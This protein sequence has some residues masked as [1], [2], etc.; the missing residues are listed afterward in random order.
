[1]A[2]S[3]T[4]LSKTAI[5]TLRGVL[6]T[7]SF[8]IV[9][10]AEE[11]RRRIKIA[12]AA[13]DNARRI[14]AA[15]ANRGAATTA[16]IEPFDLDAHLARLEG[17][18]FVAQSHTP[19]KPYGRERRRGIEDSSASY[20]TVATSESHATVPDARP[21]NI[22]DEPI[23]LVRIARAMAAGQSSSDIPTVKRA[24]ESRNKQRKHPTVEN[25]TD[26]VV[27]MS[28]QASATTQSV[29]VPSL[30]AQNNAVLPS[31]DLE[32]EHLIVTPRDSNEASTEYNEA[33]AV[34]IEAVQALPQKPNTNDE[35][36]HIFSTAVEAL[37]G[38]EHHGVTRRSF[39]EILKDIVVNLL[40]YS[41]DMTADEMRA[42]LKASLFLKRSLV[43][44][45]TRF[46]AWMDNYRPEDVVHVS[47]T[48]IA[49]FTQ[50][51]QAFVWKDGQLIQELIRV[52]STRCA[53]LAIKGYTNLKSAGLFARIDIPE[54]EY[55]IRREAVIAACAA[56]Q[57]RFIDDEMIVLRQ[58][59]GDDVVEA[60]FGLQA[61]LMARQ[62]TL[63]ACDTLFDS[64]RDL[65]NCKNPSSTEFQGHLHHLTDLFAKA[66]DAEQLGQWLKYVVKT[67]GMALQ[68]DWVFSVLNEYAY[69]HDI[70]GM[71]VWMEFCLGHGLKVDRNFVTEWKKTCRGHLRF[72]K[73]YLQ[74]LW[75]R[76][77][78]VTL[79]PQLEG[80]AYQVKQRQGDLSTH[81]AELTKNK[82][83]GKACL[84]FEAALSK[85]R[86]ICD[87]SLQLALEA[88]VRASQGN[89]EPA[90][91]LLQ[92]VRGHGR[93]TTIAQH[94]FLGKEIGRRPSGDIKTLLLQAV[95]CG[96]I[97]PADIYTLAVKK[98]VEKDLYA[99]HE[100]LQLGVRQ[101]GHGKLAF[102][103]HCFAKLLFIHIA[104]HQY[105]AAQQLVAEFISN[106]PFW[107]GTKLCKESIKFGI[108]ELTKRVATRRDAGESSADDSMLSC[109]LQLTEAL[110]QA[111][112]ANVESRHVV[113][114]Q[115][116]IADMIVQLVEEAANRD[117]AVAAREW[118]KKKRADKAARRLA[119]SP[120]TEPTLQNG[121][122]AHISVDA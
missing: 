120:Q 104:T 53:K 72:S 12:R 39:R 121:N 7:T 109:E 51:E 35:Q 119:F 10:L 5:N 1:M 19:R 80:D 34:L 118:Q 59:K 116:T 15:K 73:D 30:S 28:S 82:L 65:E 79:L 115:A 113:G 33:V 43:T 75:E 111:L 47:R 84:A 32:Y 78:K 20:T 52:Q 94:R 44:I 17:E 16:I 14:H 4:A 88:Q 61:A 46:L 54:Q 48:I 2:S 55:A 114:Y 41:V 102:N 18:S 42:V 85:D 97:V 106:R 50:P 64:L 117:E 76:L 98:V 36:S 99:A 71:M 11:R 93:D 66:H 95:E 22:H 58:L 89:A 101:L 86:E 57:T 26:I 6:F 3:S 91:R 90:L 31:K 13:V 24:T 27:R 25:K 69:Y 60:D 21:R 105:D 77:A 62:V 112:D 83:W 92:R 100:I 107:H 38:V 67:Y 70:E 45:L 56:G 81:L 108:R 9:L 87:L 49:F 8:S 68:S 29:K 40:K 96:C 103:G 122:I 37:Q 74:M 63:G 23:S 110:Q